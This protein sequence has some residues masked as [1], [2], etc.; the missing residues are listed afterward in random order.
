MTTKRQVNQ[1]GSVYKHKAIPYFLL[2]PNS[3]VTTFRL[4]WKQDL[5][6]GCKSEGWVKLDQE[7]ALYAMH[8]V[9]L[10]GVIAQS[11]PYNHLYHQPGPQLDFLKERILLWAVHLASQGDIIDNTTG[12]FV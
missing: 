9:G 12:H 4:H 3:S 2:S 11:N 8:F 6:S 1:N 10:A 7:N 5:T